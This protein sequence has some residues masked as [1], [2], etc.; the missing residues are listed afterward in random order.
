MFTST[1]NIF[2]F[3]HGRMSVEAYTGQVDWLATSQNYGKN[4]FFHSLT[5]GPVKIYRQRAMLNPA[6]VFPYVLLF[7]FFIY[8]EKLFIWNDLFQEMKHIT[9]LSGIN[10]S[11]IL[12]CVCSCQ[13]THLASCFSAS[14][15]SSSNPMSTADTSIYGSQT[16]KP[17]PIRSMAVRRMVLWG[18]SLGLGGCSSRK[19]NALPAKSG[20]SR[21]SV[22]YNNV[23]GEGL[24]ENSRSSMLL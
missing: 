4:C 5:A 17:R 1:Y 20:N 13:W 6:Y 12:H 2:D 7:V 22:K 18:G 14:A 23:W 11:N 19:V 9:R 21:N 10:N 8:S 24:S 15:Q 3:I 16:V